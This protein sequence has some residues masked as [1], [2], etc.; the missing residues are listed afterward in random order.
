MTTEQLDRLA[1]RFKKLSADRVPYESLW[2]DCYA[3]ALPYRQGLSPSMDQGAG[4]AQIY[5]ATALDAVDQ[6]AASLLAQLTPPWSRWFGLGAG[7]DLPPA[8]RVTI[9]K[10]L[11]AISTTL[12]AHF[13]RSNFTV[14]IHQCFLD[15]V[16]GGT[17]SL[18]FEES[19]SGSDSAFRFRAV[20]LSQVY[21]AEGSNGQLTVTFRRSHLTVAEFRER[22][23]NVTLEDDSLVESPNGRRIEVIEAVEPHGGAFRYTA[24]RPNGRDGKPDSLRTGE[25]KSPPFINFRWMKAPGE[26][27]GRSPIM[28]ALPDI[29]TAKIENLGWL[30]QDDGRKAWREENGSR[31]PSVALEDCFRAIHPLRG[32][33]A[34]WWPT[35][36]VGQ[37]EALYDLCTALC[38]AY[39]SIQYMV[40]HDEVS[41]QKY[42]PGP[43]FELDSWRAVFG[44]K[45]V[46][47]EELAA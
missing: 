10:E 34:Y 40:G 46:P 8:E 27:W 15:L 42:D 39:P 24:F 3:V 21:I 45:G 9:G 44:I 25:F 17:A 47:E 35:Y 2:R 26:A 22:F 41:R 18:L 1:N 19:P 31:T 30:N 38:E 23:R 20:P 37:I 13:D 12:Q 6:L 43:A 14:E 33:R 5:D 36:P 7:N 29:R 4:M 11:E 32:G 28:K 16:V